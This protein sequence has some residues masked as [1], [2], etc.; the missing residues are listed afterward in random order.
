[1]HGA[2]GHYAK[3]NKTDGKGYILY[4]LTYMWNKKKKKK[5][6]RIIDSENKGVVAKGG[7]K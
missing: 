4:E 5:K 1:M 3:W 6:N 7:A 2:R